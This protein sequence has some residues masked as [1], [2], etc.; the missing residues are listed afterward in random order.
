MA[1]TAPYVPPVPSAPSS[2]SQTWSKTLGNIVNSLVGKINSGTTLTLTA[3]ADTTVL[4]DP[5]LFVNSVLVFMPQTAHAAA[6][7]TGI[8]V[9]SQAKGT[10][11]ISHPNDANIDKTFSIAILG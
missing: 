5:R 2:Y 10:A 9:A 1:T 4:T 3:N 7:L 6:A 11:T 8:Y